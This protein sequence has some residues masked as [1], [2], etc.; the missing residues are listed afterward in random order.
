M[1]DDGYDRERS[2]IDDGS[3]AMWAANSPE[4]RDTADWIEWLKTS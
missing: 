1:F 3:P 2:D 4:P